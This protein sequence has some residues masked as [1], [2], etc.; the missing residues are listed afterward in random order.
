MPRSMMPVDAVVMDIEGTT[1]SIDFVMDVLYPYARKHLPNFVRRHRNEPQVASIM[2]EVREIGGVW[3]D[4]A[5][6]VRLC[7][8][9]Q[10]DR[11]VTPLKT[12][13]G[14]I[15][16]QG[17]RSGELVSH[18]YPDVAP[19]LRSWHGRGVRLFIY[20]SGS[21]HAQRLIFGHTVD[22]DLTA[23]LAGYFDTRMGA[24]GE[25][26]S[27]R[28]IAQAIGLPPGRLLFLSD[29][30]AELDAARR[31]GYQTIW[32]VRGGLQGLAAAHRRATTF[33]QIPI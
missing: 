15:W 14:L 7:N 19:V 28:R 16:E 6:V 1:T 5:V 11:K 29:V 9:M 33:D 31:S 26:T 4:E 21:A 30:R 3:N 27:Y 12:L 2:D 10:S 20:S 8:W 13:Q 24:K 18:L 25:A 17:Y 32:L 23:L 22:G